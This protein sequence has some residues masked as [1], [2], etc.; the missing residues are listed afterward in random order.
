MKAISDIDKKRKINHIIRVVAVIIWCVVI[1]MFSA[2][3]SDESNAQSN[4][5]FEFIVKFVNPVYDSMDPEAQ[6]R[7][8]DIATFIIRKLAHF[9][10]YA[11]LGMLAFSALWKVQ[12]VKFRG[13]FALIF[14]FLYA[15]SDEIHQ[16][17]VPGRTGQF[18]DVMIDTCGVA[19]GIIIAILI[20]KI[21]LKHKQKK[22]DNKQD[23][24]ALAE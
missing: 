6:L 12:K 14:G 24:Q 18:R 17:F 15:S 2:N 22:Q 20:R 8:H 19:F 16:L 1:F 11:I 7:Y 13:L 5:L 10:E 23:K 21:Y 4:W 3:D 9:T